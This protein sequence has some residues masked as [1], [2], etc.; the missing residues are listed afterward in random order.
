[1][2]DQFN[3][4]QQNPYG[5]PDVNIQS[6][7][8]SALAKVKTPATLLLITGVVSIIGSILTGILPTFLPGILEGV[9]EQMA[10]QNPD[11]DAAQQEQF[12]Q[13]ISM[14]SGVQ[15]Y[16]SAAIG[17]IGG[18][19][20]CLGASKMKNLQSYGLSM[21]GCIVAICPYLSA[22]CGCLFPI[23]IGIWGIVV[24]ANQDVKSHFS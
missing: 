8:E 3:A 1:M 18:V 22:C 23:A 6:T 15:M 5:A 14:T 16:I 10:A 7:R 13:L 11:F 19:I 2:S 24:L 17:L 20:M 9:V 21:A 12:E 4:P